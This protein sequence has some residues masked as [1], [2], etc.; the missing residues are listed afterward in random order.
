M[1]AGLFL[2]LLWLC[3]CTQERPPELTG[4]WLRTQPDIVYYFGDD[5]RFWQSDRIGE[6]W[7]W[8]RENARVR[9]LGQPERLWIVSFQGPDNLR[10]IES[11]TFDLRR[12]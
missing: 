1:R 2:S 11:D 7:I 5:S 10:V 9:L 12:K 8:K 6:Q 3:S 4:E